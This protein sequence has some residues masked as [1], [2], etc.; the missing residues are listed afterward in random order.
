ML[1]IT[2]L[3]KSYGP[4]VLLADASLQV[5]RGDRIGL[6]GPN[7]AGKSTLLRIVLEQIEPDAGIV[8]FQKGTL[9]GYL[10]Q[11]SADVGDET[12]LELATA[13][14]EELKLLRR[15]IVAES[16]VPDAHGLS[17]ENCYQRFD[18]LDGYRL[19]AKAGKILG[20]LGFKERDLNR[21]VAELSGGWIM[22]AHL[23]R[24]LVQEPDLLML[25]EPT[26]HL[27]LPSLRWLQ[28]HLSRFSG[29][30]LLISHDREFLNTVV[31]SIVDLERRE[32]KR[33]RGNFDSFLDQKAAEEAQVL[34]AYSNQQKEIDRL[35]SFV[36]RFRAKNTKAR[37]AQSKLKQIER[38]D[39]VQAP[40]R[41]ERS[42]QFT[43]PQPARS[44][45]RVI[46]LQD[47]AHAYGTLEVYR[48]LDFEVERGQR[49]GLVGPN[50]AGKT[51]LLKL[52]AGVE[53]IQKGERSLGHNVE[54]G[55]FSQHR[56][57]NLDPNRSVL[58]EAFRS[59]SAVTET[60]ARDV[61]G[62]F[63]F[64]GDD[65]FKTVKVLSGGEKSRLALV[66]LL[67]DPPNLLVMD[68]PTT[69]LD[70]DSVEALVFALQQF[71][72]TLIFVS[73]D[74]HLLRSLAEHIVHVEDGTLAHYFGGY[75]YYRDRVE[76][77]EKEEESAA[78]PLSSPPPGSGASGVKT[79]KERRRSEAI[80][81]QKKSRQVQVRKAA[82]E[83]LERRVIELENRL[84]E[85]AGI[86]SDRA[87]YRDPE[88]ARTLRKEETEK[89]E[90]LGQVTRDW[91]VAVEAY[92]K[93]V[94]DAG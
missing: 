70:I 12:V 82:V 89:K 50:G 53:A 71:E 90:A 36:N 79:S 24:L 75:D 66:K 16:E 94:E 41:E 38:M 77:L 59:G 7:G 9:L 40:V 46:R 3:S 57:E 47:V 51:T 81:R 85:L 32:L 25:D 45:Q 42:I 15:I 73:H 27:D 17:I 72:G 58:S 43:F 20:G 55:Y 31:D 91:E 22:R 33:Y 14:T 11:E 28:S 13:I 69:H 86:L 2:D 35:M 5:N 93:T 48:H 76:A 67:L 19:E 64:R 10:P 63:M 37:Q 56:V 78:L 4:K 1:T 21:P 68:E 30:L 54:L 87:V 49:I 23:A 84:E 52:L 92:T 88:Q 62:C 65:V 8:R 39:K 6:V 34:A 61:L 29:G 44:G 60:H 74:I 26:N 18:E 83:G 80:E